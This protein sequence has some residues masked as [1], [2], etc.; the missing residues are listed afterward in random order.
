MV[1]RHHYGCSRVDL[2]ASVAADA[3]PRGPEARLLSEEQVAE[4]NIISSDDPAWGKG[5]ST[6]AYQKYDLEKFEK[7]PFFLKSPLFKI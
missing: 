5:R 6:L 3:T 1:T 2:G 7:V 4:D